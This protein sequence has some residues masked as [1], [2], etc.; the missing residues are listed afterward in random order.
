MSFFSI[1]GFKRQSLESVLYYNEFVDIFFDDYEKLGDDDLMIEDNSSA[2]LLEFQSFTDT[3]HSKDTT[4]AALDW[5]P[6]QRG[7][8]A[9]SCVKRQTI[10]ER[11]E[12]GFP[13]YPKSSMV[14]IWSF[15]DPIHPLVINTAHFNNF[16]CI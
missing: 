9:H 4:I 5:Y 1:L 16:S 2:G 3:I 12:A 14:L 13:I 10:D 15:Q 8:I 11:I 6:L 7:V